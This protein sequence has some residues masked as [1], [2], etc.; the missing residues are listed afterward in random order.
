MSRRRACCS[1]GGEA[2]E[3]GVVPW[4]LYGVAVMQAGVSESAWARQQPL[5]WIGD[6]LLANFNCFAS[7]LQLADVALSFVT[8]A[9]TQSAPC[10]S[11]K[12]RRGFPLS[13]AVRAQGKSTIARTARPFYVN[14]PRKLLAIIHPIPTQNPAAA[15]FLNDASSGWLRPDWIRPPRHADTRLA[16]R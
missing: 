10:E 8:T 16:H 7:K 12:R 1:W 14:I 4:R 11:V 15:A 13:V 3:T 5:R 2:G 6:F 9:F